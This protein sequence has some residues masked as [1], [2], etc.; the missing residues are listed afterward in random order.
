MNHESSDEA[1]YSGVAEPS[2]Y[3]LRPYYRNVGVAGTVFFLAV[4]IGSILAICFD[5]SIKHS[6]LAIAVISLLWGGF[7]LLGLWVIAAFYREQLV[8]GADTVVQRGVFRTTTVSLQAVADLGWRLN[9]MGGSVVL[10]GSPNRIKI[11]FDNFTKLQRREIAERLNRSVGEELQT[12]W[13]EFEEHFLTTSPERLQ[14]RRRDRRTVSF[15]MIGLAIVFTAMG[16]AGF[17]EHLYAV[18]V[19]NLA[20][21]MRAL[22]LY[23][24]SQN[25]TPSEV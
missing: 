25:E 1:V 6:V 14:R 12:G 10:K 9:P 21:G 3:R 2:V 15:A 16:L 7:T 22:W 20:I 4:G 13:T 17:G 24:R 8:L 18:A 5:E 11:Y 23:L 19:L